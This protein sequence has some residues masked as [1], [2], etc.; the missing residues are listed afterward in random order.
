MM[1]HSNPGMSMRKSRTR[2]WAM[3]L[4]VISAGWPGA[5]LTAPSSLSCP[6]AKEFITTLE[7]LRAHTEYA[8]GEEA[9]R[10]TAA[11][12]AVGCEG[13]AQ[14]FVRTVQILSMAGL[15]ARDAFREGIDLSGRTTA[16]AETY[17]T[18]FVAA[19]N[20]D[21]LDLDLA[22][23]VRIARS[24]AT[25]FDGDPLAVRQDFDELVAFCVGRKELN[26]PRP[27]CA[28]FAARMARHGQAFSGGI[29]GP[30]L[31]TLAFLSSDPRGPGLATHEALRLA[32]RLVA[33]GPTVPENF[34]QAYRYA[35]AKGGLDLASQQAFAFA[36]SLAS[37]GRQG[38]ARAVASVPQASPPSSPT[39][40]ER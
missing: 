2:Q 25:E 31:D 27:L 24:L 10:K 3:T 40:S 13:A 8:I 12:V 39:K 35:V 11:Q 33:T 16:E 26:L 9:A 17:I 29:S 21:G 14:R 4:L 6:S 15:S 7:Y 1:S 37:G 38:A 22:S 20:R 5:A 36:D 32:E 19:F 30:F 18:V 28:E 34:V 23:S